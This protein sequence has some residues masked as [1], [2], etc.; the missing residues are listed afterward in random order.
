MTSGIFAGIFPQSVRLQQAHGESWVVVRP[1]RE[2]VARHIGT[3]GVTATR[4]IELLEPPPSG[5]WEPPPVSF[6]E[7]VTRSAGTLPARAERGK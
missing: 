4:L 7:F 3:D 5:G 2:E 1:A 6:Q